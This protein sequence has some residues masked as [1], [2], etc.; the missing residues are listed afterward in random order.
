MA[1]WIGRTLSKVEIR[2]RLG[3]SRLAEV[4]LGQHTTLNRLVAVKIFRRLLIED[5]QFPER[6]HTEAG[7]VAA[8]RHPNIVQIL[9]FDVF[10]Q[11]PY[12]VMEFISGPSLAEYLAALQQSDRRLPPET[13]TRLIVALADALDYAHRR[14]RVHRDIKPANI[15]LRHDNGPIDLAGPLAVDVEPVLTDFG[16]AQ[17][18][19]TIPHAPAGTIFG[20]LA[21]MSPEQARGEC[22]DAR[23]DLYSLGAIFYEMLAGQPP[24]GEVTDDTPLPGVS[25]RVQRVLDRA[26]ARKPSDRYQHAS[27]FAIDLMAAVFGATFAAQPAAVSGL[28]TTLELLLEQAQTYER[29]LPSNNYPA[30]AAVAALSRLGEQALNEARDLAATLPTPLTA[31]PFSPREYEV[32]ILAASGL[33]NKEIAYRLGLSE[34]TV[35][36][37]MNSIFNKSGTDSRTEAVALALRKGWLPGTPR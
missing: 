9:D 23:S 35:Q 11:R 17:L 7:A 22:V 26:L 29:A 20:T 6:F 36:F 14:G 12:L 24:S 34:R 13:A 18:S 8:L 4:Y 32:L 31:H 30:R 33:T 5:V 3:H 28:L 21:Y 19:D 2:Q 16:V 15:L 10:E 1:E 27:E 25:G 37:H